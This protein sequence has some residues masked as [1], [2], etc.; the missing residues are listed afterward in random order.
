M[1]VYH[2]EILLF[3]LPILLAIFIPVNTKTI[4]FSLLIWLLLSVVIIVYAMG[5]RPL[6]VV[7]INSKKPLVAIKFKNNKYAQDFF[8]I[9]NRNGKII[10]SWQLV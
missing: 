7:K 3:L 1:L 2:S 5:A 10:K 4:A 8:E 9:N 6:T